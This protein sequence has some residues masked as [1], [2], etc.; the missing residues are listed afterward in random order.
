V[1][2]ISAKRPHHRLSRFAARHGVV[3]IAHQARI[4]MKDFISRFWYVSM[5]LLVLLVLFALCG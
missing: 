3:I 4:Q 2:G 5:L 1:R